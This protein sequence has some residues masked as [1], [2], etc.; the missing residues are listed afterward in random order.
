MRHLPDF[1]TALRLA[2]SPIVAWLVLESRFREALALV[3]LAGVT[4]WLDGF[5]A[6]RLGASGRLGVI[7]D[8]LADKILL[9]TLFVVL[10]VAR[11]V[12]L[13]LLILTIGRDLVIVVGAFLLRV[14]RDVRRFTPSVLGK[15]STFFQIVLVLLVLMNAAFP[16][17]LIFWLEVTAIVLS[18]LF[19]AWSG[20]DYVRLG[21]RMAARRVV[22]SF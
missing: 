17:Q 4:D 6:R 14:F 8:P 1:I 20:I 7:L 19:T 13:W 9:V 10:A 16:Y 2:A 22:R 21:I 11:L 5:T 12:P 3:F 18:T 15:V